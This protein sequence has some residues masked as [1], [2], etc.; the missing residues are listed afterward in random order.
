MTIST[1]YPRFLDV[2]DELHDENTAGAAVLPLPYDA[3]TSWKQGTDAGPAR[4]IEASHHIE[5]YDEE[6]ACNV[7]A[8]TGG[9]VTYPSLKPQDD[10][11]AARE[12]IRSHVSALLSSRRP[13]IT[14]GGEHSITFP[15]VEAHAEKWP[16]LC[17]LQI[18]AHADLR[19][20]YNGSPYNHACPMKRI[21]DMGI[22]VTAVGIRSVDES[23]ASLLNGPLRRTFLDCTTA[24]RISDILQDI[25]ASLP[26]KNVYL[27]ID[28]D[29]ISP[30]EMPAVGTPIPGGLSWYELLS[31]LRA[32]YSEK[33][34]IGADVVELMPVPGLH[35]S[36]SL[37][38]RLVYK[39]IGYHMKNKQ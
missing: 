2:E 4:I 28:L 33:D 20:E 30:A 31:L 12:T 23:E 32:L 3:T 27:T 14:L 26:S 37:A 6:L 18:D 35:G 11:A 38:A 8:E 7:A 21:L 1:D 39:L 9:I 5:F 10:P 22:H 13:L 19:D 24:G 15:L 36:D 25:V 34:V 17:V 16:D 29:G